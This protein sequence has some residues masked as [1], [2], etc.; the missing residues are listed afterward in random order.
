MA[1]AV[2]EQIGP[3]P[4]DFPRA[5]LR[6]RDDLVAIGHAYREAAEFAERMAAGAVALSRRTTRRVGSEEQTSDRQS[7]LR[8]SYSVLCSIKATAPSLWMSSTSYRVRGYGDRW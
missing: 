1:A 4:A 2:V 6:L 8:S 5:A 3:V 7:L